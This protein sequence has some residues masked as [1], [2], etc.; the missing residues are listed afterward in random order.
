MHSVMIESSLTFSCPISVCS[1][2]VIYELSPL[3]S[4][5]LLPHSPK[6]LIAWALTRLFGLLTCLTISSMES[7]Y[8]SI[9]IF[10]S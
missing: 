9:S 4:L 1:M 10:L 8:W 3:F 7:C 5:I 2:T 6:L